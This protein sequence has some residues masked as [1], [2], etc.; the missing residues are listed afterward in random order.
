MKSTADRLIDDYL[1]RLHRELAG[2]PRTR[3]NELV[4]EISQHI[5]EARA[6]LEDER[7]AEIRTLL[8]RLGDPAEIAAEARERVGVKEPQRGNGLDILALVLL[9]VG[10]LVLPVIG[11][12]VGVVLLWAS[13]AWTTGEKLIGTLL[14]PG[15]LALPLFFAVVA[16]S[17]GSCSGPVG[18]GLECSPDGGAPFLATTFAIVLFI[19]PLLTVAFLA[20]RMRRGG[21]A[22]AV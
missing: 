11:W 2:V 20:H 22:P 6:G 7:E 3:R 21:V 15:G 10:G 16:A 9:L 1:N 18:G 13:S 19:T 17:G 14:V 5:A 12:F 8:D 4:E